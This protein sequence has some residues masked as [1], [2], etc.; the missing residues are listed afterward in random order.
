MERVVI[1][2]FLNEAIGRSLR[3]YSNAVC[4]IADFQSTFGLHDLFKEYEGRCFNFGLAERTMVSA[5]AGFAQRGK[6]PIIVS[7]SSRILTAWSEL[8]NDIALPNLNVKVLSL[9]SGITAGQD[10][11]AFHSQEDLALINQLQNFKIIS[12]GD[13]YDAQTAFETLMLDYAPV[14][15]RLGGSSL[16]R[17]FSRKHSFEFGDIDILNE[18]GDVCIFVTGRMLDKAA[19]V[20]KMLEEENHAV[21]LVNISSI[22]PLDEEGIVDCLEGIDYFVT[23]EDH[24]QNGGLSDII[25]RYLLSEKKSKLLRIGAQADIKN[26]ASS[27]FLEEQYGLTSKKIFQKIINFI[28]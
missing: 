1:T 10:G 19:Q 11:P 17:I 21:R 25:A 22:S 28:S 26:F 3:D 4:L 27:Q 15:M 24:S 6:I 2:K 20:T 12:S 9:F 16:A 8:R 7:L 23:L 13:Y 5:A 18:G 14:Y